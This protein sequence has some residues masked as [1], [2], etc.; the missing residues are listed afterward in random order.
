M[1]KTKPMVLQPTSQIPTVPQSPD[2][3]TNS[4]LRSR[5]R[6]DSTFNL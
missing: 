5:T 3:A 2:F 4:R 6:A 1:P